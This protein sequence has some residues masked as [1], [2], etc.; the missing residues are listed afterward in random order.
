MALINRSDR[1][2]SSPG[3]REISELHR[4]P[5]KLTIFCRLM[6][7]RALVRESKAPAALRHN[8]LKIAAIASSDGC[9]NV[10]LSDFE[11]SDASGKLLD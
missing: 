1:D 5:Y 8:D 10:N 9:A 3:V 7:R 4:Q 2:M 6:N 11:N